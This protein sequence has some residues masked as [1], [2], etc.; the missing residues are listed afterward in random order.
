MAKRDTFLS[1]I[2]SCKGEEKSVRNLLIDAIIEMLEDNCRRLE[3][4]W[5]YF[6]TKSSHPY[7]RLEKIGLIE[8]SYMN[9][10]YVQPQF[11]FIN[12]NNDNF[13]YVADFDNF[14]TDELISL[15]KYLVKHF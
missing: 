3:L 8:H 5:Y 12:P 6:D 11:Y 7:F 9:T 15:M 14:R 4:P 2:A 1:D 10:T 13:T